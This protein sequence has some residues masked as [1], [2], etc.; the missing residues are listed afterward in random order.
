MQVGAPRLRGR[1]ITGVDLDGT[2]A[3]EVVHGQGPRVL[4]H[5]V[6]QQLG[7]TAPGGEVEDR[8]G[9]VGGRDLRRGVL[10]QG[11][12]VGLGQAPVDDAGA[13]AGGATRALDTGS[14][15]FPGRHEPRHPPLGIEAGTTG[16]P[17]IDDD[18]HAGHRERR[19]RHR[20]GDDDPALTVV[21]AP[22]PEDRVLVGRR[23]AAGERV[24]AHGRHPG[25]EGRRGS[26]QL[27]ADPVGHLVD[28]A[29]SRGEDEDVA[30]C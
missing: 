29:S 2:E 17:R 23:G 12:P 13:E 9:E 19:F 5:R 7:V 22:G 11:G 24:D 10:G 15:R 30:A 18:A 28:L 16:E 14:L 27:P 25:T 1:P 3:D 4:R 6:G 21:G 20:G 8:R 26:G